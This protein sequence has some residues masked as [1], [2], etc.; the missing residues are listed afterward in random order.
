MY[1]NDIGLKYLAASVIKD[2]YKEALHGL[3]TLYAIENPDRSKNTNKRYNRMVLNK[4]ATLEQYWENAKERV[5]FNL[6]FLTSH[7][8]EMYFDK[9]CSDDIVNAIFRNAEKWAD[10]E[11]VRLP[12][13]EYAD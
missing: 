8:R 2:A 12:I 3:E 11:D 1:L 7:K 5:R 10:G 4:K 13:S 6:N 9:L